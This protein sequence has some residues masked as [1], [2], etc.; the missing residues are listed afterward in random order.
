MLNILLAD[1]DA[2]DRLFFKEAMDEIN[3][4]TMVSVVNDGAQLIEYLNHSSH[5]LPDIIFLDINMPLKNGLECLRELRQDGRYKDIQIVIFSTSG[6]D[7]DIEAAYR[8]GANGYLKKPGDFTQLKTSL[9][10]VLM[11]TFHAIS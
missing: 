8:F 6:A 2:D 9:T 11:D 7:T 1:D 5:Y 3:I 4:D 10:N